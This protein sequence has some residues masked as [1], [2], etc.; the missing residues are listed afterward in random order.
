MK[1]KGT[2]VSQGIAIGKAHLISFEEVPIPSYEILESNIDEEVS[3]FN[4]A[5]NLVI[6]E[7]ERVKEAAAVSISDESLAIFDVHIAILKDPILKRNTISRIV[8]ERKNAESAFATS[9]RMVLEVLEKSKDPYFKERVIDIKDLASKVQMRMLGNHKQHSLDVSDPILV[10]EQ[11]S[12][13]Q[14]GPFQHIVKGFI[15][16]HGGKTSH[17]AILARSLEIPAIV[18]VTGISSSISQGDEI[19]VDGVEG[20]IIVNPTSDEKKHY[21]EKIKSYKEKRGKLLAES[22][23]PSR[24]I[25]GHHIK[26]KC[27]IDLEEELSKALEVGAEGIGLYRSEFL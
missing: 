9:I 8:K 4:K 24:T 26:L 11:L 1:L 7:L 2:P 18:G 20:V 3:R 22:K 17:T 15:T 21:I 23:K 5:I 16:E 13:S 25:D 19:I 14:T 10:S 27:N 12:P 6:D